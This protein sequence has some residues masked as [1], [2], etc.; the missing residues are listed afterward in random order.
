MT[1]FQS[2]WTAL[3]RRGREPGFQPKLIA[4]MRRL[5][6]PVARQAVWRWLHPDTMARTQCSME[7][8]V[9]LLKAA[10]KVPHN[11]S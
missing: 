5:G 7:I 4:E 2:Q 11:Q 3:I 9:L 8:G 10:E 6:R 1:D